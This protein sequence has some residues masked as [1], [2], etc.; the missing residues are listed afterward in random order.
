MTLRLFAPRSVR[1]L[2]RST[3]L[4]IVLSGAL[5]TPVHAQTT[6]SASQYQYRLVSFND[7]L[8][9]D[10]EMF[11]AVGITDDRRIYGTAYSCDANGC[12]PSVTVYQSGKLTILHGGITHAINSFGLVGGSLYDPVKEAEQAAVFT[13]RHVRLIPRLPGETTS[14][15]VGI[16]N[17]GTA[18][19]QS[20]NE[21][22]VPQF[23]LYDAHSRIMPI[24]FGPGHTVDGLSINDDNIIAG[25]IARPGSPDRAFRYDATSRVMTTL[26]PI[27][28]DPNSWGQAINRRD[29]VL[30]YSWG[31]GLERIGVWRHQKFQT[32]FVEGTP[33]FPTISKNLLWN[34]NGLIVITNSRNDL[35]SYLV[36][37]PNVRIKVSDQTGVLPA[38][39][40]VKGINAK[41]D[42]IG[43]AGPSY[44][45]ADFDF[46]L[47]RIKVR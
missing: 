25:T 28:A 9:P 31:A 40:L 42:L 39:T 19:V 26:D 21:A 13:G 7:A 38:W 43:S 4:A 29:D 35:N 6:P 24:D 14:Y 27:R 1:S 8:V 2:G 12:F 3:I 23:Y 36:P 37:E 30:G 32:Y 41:G 18:L 44:G 22:D 47:E 33:E 17:V 20:V 46:F 34:R 15:V 5:V 45:V 10:V 16:T 11:D